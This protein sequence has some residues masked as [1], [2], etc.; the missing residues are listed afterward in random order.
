MS[1]FEVTR[2]QFSHKKDNMKSKSFS[3]FWEISK[4]PLFNNIAAKEV[5]ISFIT[6]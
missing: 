1:A 4:P 2:V 3:Q 5:E 6:S